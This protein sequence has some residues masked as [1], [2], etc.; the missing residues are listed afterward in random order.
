MLKSALISLFAYF[1]RQTPD[2]PR[3]QHAWAY[4]YLVDLNMYIASMG[5]CTWKFEYISVGKSLSHARQH[6]RGM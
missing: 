3:A 1:G 5:E 6:A 4:V 2:I